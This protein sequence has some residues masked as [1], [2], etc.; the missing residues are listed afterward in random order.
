MHLRTARHTD[1]P[2]MHA[3]RLSVRE[4]RLRDPSKVTPADYDRYVLDTGMAWVAEEGG[5]VLG[6]AIGDRADASIWALFVAPHV[7]RRGIG[8]ALLGRLTEE[9]F[10]QGA[11]SLSLSTDPDT[12]AFRV[13]LAAGWRAVE[14]LRSGEVRLEL[15]RRTR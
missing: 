2:A 11:S 14:T 4:N 10:R 3:L 12:R 1:I 9:L 6:F 5:Q 7:E 8:R 13:Y 15:N